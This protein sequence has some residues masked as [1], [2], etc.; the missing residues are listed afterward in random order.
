MTPRSFLFLALLAAGCS[1]S[2]SEGDPSRGLGGMSGFAAEDPSTDPT[3]SFAIFTPDRKCV[4]DGGS[5]ATASWCGETS[6]R[7]SWDAQGRI[8]GL[9]GLCL[10]AQNREF[11]ADGDVTGMLDLTPFDLNPAHF[12]PCD[13]GA[14]QRWSR[15]RD[16]IW[17]PLPNGDAGVACL[18]FQQQSLAS[19]MLF[20]DVASDLDDCILQQEWRLSDLPPAAGPVPHS[21]TAGLTVQNSW[22][23]GFVGEIAVTLNDPGIDGW[24]MDWVF[25]DAAPDITSMWNVG[26][27]SQSG[28]EVQATDAG[29]NGTLGNNDTVTLGFT[30]NGEAPDPAFL[31]F[32]L[33]ELDC[34]NIQNG[35]HLNGPPVFPVWTGGAD[36]A[37]LV[38]GDANDVALGDCA[39][40]ILFRWIAGELATFDDRCLEST[41]DGA[42]LWPC[43]AGVSQTWARDGDGALYTGD[44]TLGFVCLDDVGGAL[45]TS[46]GDTLDDCTAWNQGGVP[47]G[48]LPLCTAEVVATHSWPGGFVGAATFTWN[49]LPIDNWLA[50]WTFDN[51]EV[52]TSFWNAAGWQNGTQANAL[53]LPWNGSMDPGDSVTVGFVAE[54]ELGTPGGFLFRGNSCEGP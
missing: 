44:D 41:S 17:M 40:P 54:G 18:E 13:G 16:Q 35:N 28:A 1:T 49:G 42:Q 45:E 33:N 36:P 3:P 29:W 50:R 38:E 15:T 26:S 20:T 43:S 5:P 6:D 4:I 11:D 37:C 47:N 2:F 19:G 10:S 8:R 27:W 22:E 39:D 7:F 53:S 21:C 46:P 51:G 9:D 25:G 24:T 34:L 52:A 32:F 12:Y 30:A 48:G 31:S 14:D 23:G